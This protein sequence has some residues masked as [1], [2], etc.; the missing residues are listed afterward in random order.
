MVTWLGRESS[1]QP[2]RDIEAWV[3]DKDLKASTRQ[4]LNVNL[5]MT[6]AQLDTISTLLSQVLEAGETN[7]V[8]G[9]DFFTSLQA[10]SAVAARDPEKLANA[11][12]IAESGLVPDFLKGLP[13]KSRLMEMN[14]DLWESFGP[15]EQNAFLSSIESKIKAYQAIHDDP[16][17]WV[18]LNE[19]D[20]AD[21]HVAAVALDLLP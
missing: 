21:D 3:V 2:P 13:Y 6:K 7:Q 12:N 10:A 9:E 5:L 18:A 16:A 20:D 4:S 19:G 11:A 15:D 17:L 1:V 14:N 8:S